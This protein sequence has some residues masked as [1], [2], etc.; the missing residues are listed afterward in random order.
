MRQRKEILKIYIFWDRDSI[1]KGI[2]TKNLVISSKFIVLNY[3]YYMDIILMV[4][5]HRSIWYCS[6]S[7][8]ARTD[9]GS[10]AAGWSGSPIVVWFSGTW[11]P[12]PQTCV[13]SYP[14]IISI[15]SLKKKVYTLHL[16]KFIISAIW[17]LIHP[18]RVLHVHHVFFSFFINC[19]SLYFYGKVLSLRNIAFDEKSLFKIQW[20]S[21]N[22]RFLTF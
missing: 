7:E 19:S 8:R 15:K 11:L 22:I 13:L 5:I 21:D 2:S 10:T 4:G 12:L 20:K 14:K 6:K 1:E 3:V 9:T 18:R 17:T 16:Y